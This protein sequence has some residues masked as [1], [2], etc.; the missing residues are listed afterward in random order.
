MRYEGRINMKLLLAAINA[1]YIHSNL[2]VYS[3]RANAGE[4]KDQVEIGEYTI[5]HLRGDILAD[6][7]RRK[8]DVVAFSCYIWNIEYVKA[9]LRDLKKILPGADIWL[10]GPEVSYDCERILKEEKNVCGILVGEGETTLREL[11][12]WYHGQGELSGIKGLV[13]R[14]GIEDEGGRRSDLAENRIEA[15]VLTHSV[16]C[17]TPPRDY[18][19]LDTL[20]FPYEDMSHFRNRIIYYESS[21]GCP[22]SCSYCLSSIDKR[23]RFRNLELV[24]R[25]LQFFLDQRVPQVKFVDRTFNVNHERTRELLAFIRERDNGITN[26]HFEISAD[27]LDETEIELLQRLRSGQVQLEIGV[28]S[29]NARVLQEIHRNADFS[30]IALRVREIQ[31]NHNVHQHLDL[32]AGLPFGTME[33]FQ[34]S[35]NDVYALRPQQLQLGFLK[36]LRGSE[37]GYRASELGILQTDRPP[38][39]VLSTK[40][41][42]YG[43]LLRLKG[44]EEMVEVYYNSRQFDR[45]MELLILEFTDAFSLY[46]TLADFY[47]SEGYNGRSHSRME[48]LMILR[49]FAVYINPKM[50]KKYEQALLLDLYAREKSKSRPDFAPDLSIRKKEIY[51]FY[52]EEAETHRY[53]VLEEFRGM[54]AR[55]LMNQTHLEIIF[56][57]QERWYL[58]DYSRRD[59][60]TNDGT[61]TEILPMRTL[62]KEEST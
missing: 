53:L 60:L 32:I 37:L 34:Q 14:K 21:R 33:E 25:E 3:L 58:F 52:R 40:W 29:T 43:E 27:I 20:S 7:Y 2:A 22:F 10:G 39:E 5:N 51:E 36:V 16:I 24:K 62:C 42:S 45:T 15:A 54:N 28:Q 19:N 30:K 41:L 18:E 56:D 4:W 49:A 11:L 50:Q 6:I 26:F 17:R 48:R 12:S 44:V 23:V 35:F 8:P 1:K 31:R 59:P 47:E 57:G 38:Y 9:I 13:Y 55:Q 46:S 61:V